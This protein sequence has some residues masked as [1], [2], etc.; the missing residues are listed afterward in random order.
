MDIYS[1]SLTTLAIV[2]QLLLIVRAWRGGYLHHFPFFY[3]YL[4]YIVCSTLFLLAI[5]SVRPQLYTPLFWFLSLIAFLAEFAVIVEISDHIFQPFPAIRRL[6]Q[7]IAFA[8][9]A[10]LSVV[11]ILPSL[12]QAKPPGFLILDLALRLA[13]TKILILGILV[14]IAYRYRLLL[15]RNTGGLTLG[16]AAYLG[17]YIANFAA[18]ETFG[19]A[20][21]AGV[22]RLA[23]LLG[24]VLCLLVWTVA[25]WRLESVQIGSRTPAIAGDGRSRKELRS[26]LVRFNTLLKGLLRK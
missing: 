17:V 16:F 22:L 23:P 12:W 24:S 6:G 15:G 14:V 3:S 7:L 2:L 11:Y 25:M 4:A 26:E 19:R 8:A 21:Y 5:H 1:L 18:A 9:I 13:V 10:V 20:L